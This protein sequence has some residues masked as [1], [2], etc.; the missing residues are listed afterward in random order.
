MKT[1]ETKTLKI[2]DDGW[3]HIFIAE[4]T[5]TNMRIV[6]SFKGN[7]SWEANM[8]AAKARLAELENAKP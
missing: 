6:E 7:G 3:S 5:P 4:Y 1:N 2:Q 8:A